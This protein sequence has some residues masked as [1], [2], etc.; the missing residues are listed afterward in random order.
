MATKKHPQIKGLY[1]KH[2]R[3]VYQPPQ[4][5]GVRPK[6]VHRSTTGLKEALAKVEDIKRRGIMKG[7]T[8]PLADL[9]DAYIKSKSDS[10]EHNGVYT[11]DNAASSLRRFTSYIKCNPAKSPAG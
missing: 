6:P 4:V 10:L 1:L 7:T 11:G 2:D 3:W 8:E 5:Q 9:S